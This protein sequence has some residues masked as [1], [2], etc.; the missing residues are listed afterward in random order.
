MT[1]TTEGLMQITAPH[2]CAGLETRSGVVQRAAPIIKYMKGWHTEKV[3]E[4]CAKKS[5]KLKLLTITVGPEGAPYP[6]N[7][8]TPP[9]P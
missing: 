2:F 8:P 4:Y 7:A 9:S 1:Q 6:W 5:W 3:R